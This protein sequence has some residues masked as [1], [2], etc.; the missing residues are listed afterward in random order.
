M[1]IHPIRPVYPITW[2]Y[3]I[4]P[5]YLNVPG[6]PSITPG[7]PITLVHLITPGYLN[8]P[9]Y[10]VVVSL[11]NSSYD[12]HTSLHQEVLGKVWNTFLSDDEVGFHTQ[13]I[14][15]HLLHH[16]LLQLQYPPTSTNFTVKLVT[17]WA[18]SKVP[19]RQTQSTLHN[20]KCS[21]C[22]KL[23]TYTGD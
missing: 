15:T 11:A 2:I 3:L 21:R 7:Y 16:L 1:A 22:L 17:S 13:H 19:S 18:D 9:G 10:P 20:P 14:T 5:G 12:G 6:Y 4:T 8:V 23:H